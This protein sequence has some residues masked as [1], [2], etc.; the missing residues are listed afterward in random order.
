MFRFIG[1]LFLSGYSRL[2]HT[3]HYW[4]VEE[5]LGVPVAS[6]SMS[7]NRF[8][9][10]KRYLHLVDNSALE[11]TD[12]G[13][14]V[15]PFFELIT[16]K[17]IQFSVFAKHL[18]VDEQM[19]PYYGKH[20]AK[21]YMNN[22]P[23]KFGYKYWVLSS[24]DGYPFHLKL[25]LGKNTD[26]GD[27]TLGAFVVKEL[28]AKIQEPACHTITFYNFF[29]SYN[30]L[31]ELKEKMIAATGTIRY[32]RLKGAPLPSFQEAKKMPR[33]TIHSAGDGHVVACCWTDNKPVYVASNTYGIHPTQSKRRYS[34]S[35]Y[36]HIQV[37]CPRMI[38]EYN[39]YMGGVDLCDRFLSE[40]RPTIRGKKWWF[41]LFLHGLN[42]LVVATWRLHINLGGKMLQLDF[43]RSIACC[44]LKTNA[45]THLLA[46]QNPRHQE[47]D[48]R[49]DKVGHEV[50]KGLKEGR[51]KACQ[52]NTFYLC[53]KCNLRLHQKCFDKYHSK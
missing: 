9:T 1:V 37:D 6:Q 2:P 13:A 22:K 7:R 50:H 45:Q 31:I 43:L 49:F 28:V 24:A 12:K 11:E 32:N 47:D 46:R 19:C 10:I 21:M 30:L 15:K 27:D 53:I 29:T 17:L 41:S 51:C 18:S 25:Y 42:V 16:E 33:G 52:K 39:K 36:D 40:Y 26:R 20:S 44:L 8:T 23:I 48:V 5:D 4:S 3:K 14:K 34:Q 38:V 35:E